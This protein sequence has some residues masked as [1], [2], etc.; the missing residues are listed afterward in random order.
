ML[1]DTIANTLSKVMNYEK[2]GR[3]DLIITP[4]SKTLRKVLTIM[5]EN[6]YLGSF[7]LSQPR[8]FPPKRNFKKG[9]N[10]SDNDL[11]DLVKSTRKV[12]EYREKVKFHLFRD[13]E[14]LKQ[15][16]EQAGQ[17]S[18]FGGEIFYL[19]FPELD[20]LATE[21]RLA[22]YRIE[23]RKQLREK[24]L[25]FEPIFESGLKSGVKMTYEKRPQLIFGSLADESMSVH[26]GNECYVVDSVDQTITIPGHT[27]VVFVPDNIRPGSHLFT[28]LSDYNLPVVAVPQDE[29]EMLKGNQVQISRMDDYINIVVE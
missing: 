23:L 14:Y 4:L 6:R 29:L 17:L 1:N 11:S 10:I 28:V 18:V 24:K 7:E 13:Y 12:L 2:I 22:M 21:P 8:G 20:L 16:C 26:V 27:K 9:R 3:K 19:E 25:F 5:Q 15:L